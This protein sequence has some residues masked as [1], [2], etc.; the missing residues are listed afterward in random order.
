[1][2]AGAFGDAWGGIAGAQSTLELLLDEGHHRRGV[3][4]GTLAKLSSAAP[5]ERFGLAA[6]GRLAPGA[7]AD[8]AL[9]DLRAERTLA[10]RDLHDRHRA[11]PYAGR[12]LRG[13]VVRTL[14]RGTTVFRDGRI[15]APGPHGR[16]LRPTTGGP[17]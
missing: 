8:L 5:A 17:A 15:V 14:V 9:V 6:K 13:R 2:K 11:S 3:G 10:R 4:L 12:T 16:L 1:M 7:D